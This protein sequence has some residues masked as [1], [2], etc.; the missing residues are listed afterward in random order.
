MSH[1][2][3]TTY[4]NDHLAGSVAALELLD[5]IIELQ[6]GT[7]IQA[8]LSAIR[9][10]VEEDQI[11]LE[12]LLRQL[13]GTESRVRQAAAWL[14]EKVGRAKLR[15]DSSGK[16]ELQLL[17]ALEGLALGIQGKAALWRALRAAA[18][19]VPPLRGLNFSE[20]EQRALSQHE[21]VDRLR[22][23]AASIALSS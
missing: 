17:E 8:Q 9:T 21:R 11:L 14:T 16:R 3:L 10:E 20:L 22:L 23:Q 5:H 15:I 18:I 12:N 1:G 2:G 19:D 7:P 4:L 6:R 13:G